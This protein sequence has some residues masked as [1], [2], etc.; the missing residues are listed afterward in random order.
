MSCEEIRELFS[1]HVD[2]ALP[3]EM[4]EALAD[5]IGACHDC[6]RELARYEE[7]LGGLAGLHPAP[8]GDLGERVARDLVARGLLSSRAGVRAWLPVAAALAVFAVGLVA[9]RSSVHRRGGDEASPI[10][11][12]TRWANACVAEPLDP[13]PLDP[14]VLRATPRADAPPHLVSAG[15]YALS[16]PGWLTSHG[17]Y[18]PDTSASIESGGSTCLPL[19]EPFGTRLALTLVPTEGADAE[20]ALRFIVEVDPHRVLYARVLWRQ[21]GLTWSLEGRA[22]TT[23]LLDVAHE[24]AA[25]VEVQ[26]TAGVV[27]PT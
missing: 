8:A 23:E 6:R 26:R 16:L 24:I 14:R 20:R 11:P 17:P 4:E 27:S 10:A 5:H 2:G 15:P 12:A 13:L 25:R 18:R 1:D 21:A 3:A 19:R 22:E 9:G 7:C